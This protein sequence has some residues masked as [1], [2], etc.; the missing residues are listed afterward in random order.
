MSQTI[1]DSE[2]SNTDH[3]EVVQDVSPHS[4]SG[5]T[6]LAPQDPETDVKPKLTWEMALAFIV[7]RKML[8]ILYRNHAYIY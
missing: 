4:N 1:S 8:L 6:S 2:K 3:I 5:T 7:C